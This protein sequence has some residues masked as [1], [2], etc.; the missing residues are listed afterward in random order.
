MRRAPR[1]FFRVQGEVA[2]NG[3]QTP[4]CDLF[5]HD[6]SDGRIRDRVHIAGSFSETFP[7]SW[8]PRQ[9]YFVVTC[10]GA[11]APYRSQIFKVGYG[12]HFKGPLAIGRIVLDQDPK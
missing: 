9:C 12:E 7:A 11:K 5:V 10:E 2:V 8:F 3:Q 6:A 4:K 1:L